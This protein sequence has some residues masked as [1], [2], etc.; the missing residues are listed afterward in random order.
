MTFELVNF[1]RVYDN[2]SNIILN[3]S[4]VINYIFLSHYIFL[5]LLSLRFNILTFIYLNNFY[6][7]KVG[8]I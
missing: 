5:M 6:W 3:L 1:I 2:L 4:Y 8:D 7:K